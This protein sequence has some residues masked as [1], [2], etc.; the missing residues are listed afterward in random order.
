M[1]SSTLV[2]T[3][4]AL[5]LLLPACT[6]APFGTPTNTYS[7]GETGE[8]NAS[9]GDRDLAKKFVLVGIRRERKDGRLHVQFDLQNT[10]PGDLRIEW[11]V[12]W[13][14]SSGFNI[15]SGVNWRPTV[16]PGKGLQPIQLTAPTPEAAEFQLHFR[17]PTPI[18]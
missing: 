3:V 12:T 13:R 5:A 9:I 8:P 2:P 6:S 10:T 11:T 15:D 14:N 16:V 4:L 7:V 1:N 17:K 18:S